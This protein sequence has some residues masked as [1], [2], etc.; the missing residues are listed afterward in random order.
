[1]KKWI[2]AFGA[3]GEKC[4]LVGAGKTCKERVEVDML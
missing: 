1:M 4:V 3:V 2:Q